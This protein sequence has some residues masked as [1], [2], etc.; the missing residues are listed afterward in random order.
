MQSEDNLGG[1][2]KIAECV[3]ENQ[4]GMSVF[5]HIQVWKVR[6]WSDSGNI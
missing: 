6:E 3:L 2:I 4:L 1:M 5:N